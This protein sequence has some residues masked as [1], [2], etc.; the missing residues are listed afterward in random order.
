[1]KQGPNSEAAKTAQ[2]TDSPAVAQE[3]LVRPLFAPRQMVSH[4]TDESSAGII[5]AFMMRGSN[6]S[7][8]VQWGIEKSLWHLDFELRAK[9]DQPRPIGFWSENG[10][11][12]A[13]SAGTAAQERPME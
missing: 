12:N 11:P 13:N 1:M 9:S 2:T 10:L 7:Y 5:T 4:V 6:H 8:E 3:R